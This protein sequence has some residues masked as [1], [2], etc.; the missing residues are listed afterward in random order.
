MLTPEQEK[1][2]RDAFWE[3]FKNVWEYE[4][5]HTSWWLSILSQEIQEAEKRGYEDGYR[6]GSLIEN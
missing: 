2:I 3:K 4:E 5:E 1:K 6:D